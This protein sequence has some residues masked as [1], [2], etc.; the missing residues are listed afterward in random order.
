MK[1]FLLFALLAF[2]LPLSYVS[3]TRACNTI[4]TGLCG[5]SVAYAPAYSYQIQ[6]YALA[7]PFISTVQVQAYAP[8]QVQQ[9]YATPVCATEQLSSGYGLGASSYGVGGYSSGLRFGSVGYTSAFFRTRFLGLR[10]RAGLLGF[11]RGLIAPVSRLGALGLLA[12]GF[13]RVALGAGLGV[14]RLGLGIGRAALGLGGRGLARRGA[15]GRL[16]GGRRR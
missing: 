11:N 14:G 2:L 8:V 15:I 6:T 13:G 9:S 5:A 16:V 4:G 3:P 1:R 10:G 12:R 7:V